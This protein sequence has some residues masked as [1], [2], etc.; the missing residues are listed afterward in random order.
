MDTYQ[1]KFQF[2]L[3]DSKLLLPRHMTARIGSKKPR[4][5]VETRSLGILYHVRTWDPGQEPWNRSI[6]IASHKHRSAPSYLPSYA[7]TFPPRIISSSSALAIGL[8]MRLDL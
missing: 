7:W 4:R 1:L 6:V 2:P 8:T 5:R 3:S